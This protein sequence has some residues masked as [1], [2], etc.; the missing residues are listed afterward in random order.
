[1]P[2][3]FTIYRIGNTIKATTRE[4]DTPSYRETLEKYYEALSNFAQR[5]VQ[6]IDFITSVSNHFRSKQY[7][8][9][10]RKAI[11]ARPIIWHTG[12]NMAPV[13]YEGYD[14]LYKREC[15]VCG[16]SGASQTFLMAHFE[17]CKHKVEDKEEYDQLDF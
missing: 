10:N 9:K 14:P 2:R 3:R 5:P 1:M 6:K 15:P 17:N 7:I 11:L 8:E 12:S 4:V 16:K 13:P